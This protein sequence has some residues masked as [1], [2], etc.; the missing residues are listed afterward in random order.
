M[1]S[2]F[3][4]KQDPAHAYLCECVQVEIICCCG[5]SFDASYHPE[6]GYLDLGDGCVDEDCGHSWT[7]TELALFEERGREQVEKA[8]DWFSGGWRRG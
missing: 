6:D 7:R 3:I 2:R 4:R 8:R 5:A 1:T